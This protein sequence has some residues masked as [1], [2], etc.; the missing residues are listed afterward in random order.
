MLQSFFIGG[1]LIA[2]SRLVVFLDSFSVLIKPAIS[3]SADDGNVQVC[4]AHDVG[5]C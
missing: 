3:P 2:D 5:T 1:I 4:T